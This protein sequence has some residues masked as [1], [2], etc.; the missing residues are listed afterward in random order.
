MEPTLALMLA[1]GSAP[2]V[3]CV[4]MCGG[5]VVVFD[6]RRVIP[7]HPAVDRLRR[8]GFNAGRITSYAV[9]AA[10]ILA[11]GTYGLAHAGGAGEAIRSAILCF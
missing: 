5:I 7:V 1:A 9:R 8:P 2:G 10:A 6:G 11:S 3:N 4:G